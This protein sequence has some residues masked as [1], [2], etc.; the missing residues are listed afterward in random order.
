M[1]ASGK[2]LFFSAMTGLLMLGGLYAVVCQIPP[3]NC[4]KIMGLYF[5]NPKIPPHYCIL[6]AT[7]ENERGE[8][9]PLAINRGVL[10]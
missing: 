6:G 7:I 9:I 1:R 8:K 4:Q 5:Q 3:G 10:K 2:V